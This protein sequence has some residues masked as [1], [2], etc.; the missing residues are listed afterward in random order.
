MSNEQVALGSF[1]PALCSGAAAVALVSGLLLGATGWSFGASEAGGGDP[2]ALRAA[3]EE[4]A[5]ALHAK[6]DA[7][8]ADEAARIDRGVAQVL[9]YWSAADGDPA[10]LRAFLESE[11]IPRGDLYDQTFDRLE[12]A[13]ERVGGYLTSMERDLRRGVDLDI[14]PILPVDHI[15]AAYSPRAHVAEDL[16]DNRLAFVA[17]LNFPLT[18]LDER[19]SGGASWSRRQWA[20]TRLAQRFSSRVPAPVNQRIAEAF[21]AA[22]TYISGYNIFMHHLLDD[23]GN[24]PFPEGLRLITHWGLRD[25]LKARYADPDGLPRQ[26]MIQKVM[27]RIVR[28]EIPAAV[29]D[30]PLL[31]WNPYS[32]AVTV[33]AVKDAPAPP[34]RSAE[35]SSD[36]EADTRYRTWLDVFEA[37]RQEDPYH[38]D[39]PTFIDRRFNVDREIPEKQVE[40][41][42]ES[43][44]AAPVGPRVARLI[45]SRLGRPLEPFD[46]WYVGFRPRGRYAEAELDARTRERY[47]TP[48][49]YAADMPRMF[50]ELG[51]TPDQARFLAEHITVDPSRGAGHALGATR[52]DDNAHLR[53]RVAPDGM[54]YKGYNIAVHEMGHNVEQVFSVTSIDHT[55][56]QG[57]PNT[58]F[59]EALAFVF[60]SRDLALLGLSGPDADAARFEA[61]EAFWAAR[62]I[63]GVALVDMAAWRWL[64]AHPGATPAAFREAVVSIAR[65][66]WNRHYAG[67]FGVK[68]VPILAVYSHMIDAGLYLP[69]YPLGHL[70]AFQIESH[71]RGTPALGPEFERICKLGSITPDVWMRQ[72]VGNP[73]SAQPLLDAAAQAL[74]SIE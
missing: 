64:Y 48:E 26:K 44:L 74:E 52:R 69:D 63:A 14:G 34:G 60:Q 9:R 7:A 22:D 46:I 8:G 29:V 1:L 57:V 65:D 54:D 49:A 61:L 4:A 23:A 10:Q 33:S 59:T 28:Q 19:L 18:T 66:V 15:L 36:R 6:H 21:A 62:E 16:F 2:A 70:I 24:R 42:F 47:P 58:A 72:A 55:L 41:L 73:L 45:E 12:F 51:F 11:F 68:D 32:N 67:I 20:E 3:G 5:R 53:T 31:D 13:L 38:P 56:L 50:R 35:P 39:N 17:L 25:E 71:F 27:E 43:L 40:T 30:N 37:V